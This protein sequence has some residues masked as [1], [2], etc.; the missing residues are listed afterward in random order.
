MHVY[1]L[2]GE[3]HPLIRCRLTAPL[4]RSA[5]SLTLYRLHVRRTLTA[6]KLCFPAISYTAD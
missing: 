3:A 5:A 1:T 6:I 4:I 2:T